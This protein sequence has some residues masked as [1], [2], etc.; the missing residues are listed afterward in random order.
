MGGPPRRDPPPME[1][2]SWGAT[3]AGTEDDTVIKWGLLFGVAM[4]YNAP[5]LRCLARSASPPCAVSDFGIMRSTGL[6]DRARWSNILSESHLLG[7]PM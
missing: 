1:E 5:G 7:V 4:V 2:E 6:L 3:V